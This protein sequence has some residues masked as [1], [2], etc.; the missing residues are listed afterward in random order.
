[1]NGW[2]FPGQPLQYEPILPDDDDFRIVNHL[3]LERCGYDLENHK[4]LLAGSISHHTSLQ[5]YGVAMSLYRTRRLLSNGE[6]PELIAEHSLGIYAA[7][8]AAGCITEGDALELAARLGGCMSVMSEKKEYALGCPIGLSVGAVESSAANNGVFVANYNTS[9]H[10]LL[11]GEKEGIESALAECREAGAFSASS[12]SCEAPLHTPLMALILS[13]LEAV[14]SDYSFAEPVVPVIE[15][16]GQTTLKVSDISSFLLDELLKPVW[17]ERSYKALL[18]S[19][20]KNTVEV[21]SGNALKKFN[22]WIDSENS[23]R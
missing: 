18:Q 20:V 5:I 3:C 6:K 23:H 15:H 17:W 21:G 1:M 14:V 4:P 2:I 16:I 12:F 8:N 9:S 13:Q 10:F 19:G 7:L 11:A 22:R